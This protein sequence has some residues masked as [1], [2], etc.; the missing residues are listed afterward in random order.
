MAPADAHSLVAHMELL[1]VLEGPAMGLLARRDDPFDLRPAARL[2]DRMRAS[3]SRLNVLDT[4]RL[5]YDFHDAL[6]AGVPNA[7]LVAH[8][9][10]TW[11]QVGRMRRSAAFYLARAHRSVEEHDRLLAM[12]SGGAEPD[13]VER[14]ARRHR[15]ATLEV[16]LREDP[17][18]AGQRSL[19][20]TDGLP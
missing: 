1:A 13:A 3:L 10:Q 15:L 19:L 11:E 5:N 9:R 17:E 8:L 6:Y 2:N 4:A 20:L 14:F 18:M 7:P 12:V 16:L